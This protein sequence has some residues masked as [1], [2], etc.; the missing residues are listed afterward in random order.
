MELSGLQIFKYLPGAKKLPE[1][2][3]KKC[4][5]PTCM[6]FALK[7]AKQQTQIEKCPHAPEELCSF[8]LEASKIQQHELTMSDEIKFGGETVMFRHEKT[9]VNKTVIAVTLYSNDEEFDY[10][11]SKIKDYEIER[12]G[13]IFRVQ[14]IYLVDCGNLEACV[15]KI[16]DYGFALILETPNFEP[17]E[18]IS[19]LNPIIVSENND[20]RTFEGNVCAIGNTVEELEKSSKNLLDNGKKQ[21]VLYPD[22]TKL[23]NSE[24]IDFLTQ[25]RR[26]A[27][28]SKYEPFTYPV[29][30]RIREQNP[31]KA[32]SEASLFI[33]RY[34]N[35]LVFDL[36]NEALLTAIFTLRQNIYT[37]PQKPLQVESKVYELNNPDE[38]ALVVMTTNFALTYFAV[39]NE[40]EA[41]GYPIYLVIMP[42]DGM[43]VLTAW[44]ADK[45]TPEMAAK[46]I[47]S[48]PVLNTVKHKQLVIPGLLSHIR[49]DIQ[50]EL[51]DWEIIVGTNEAYKI[52]EFVKTRFKR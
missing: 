31:L 41:T 46:M 8:F 17:D 18:L 16:K 22:L 40:F 44:S 37:N 6:A 49:D 35:I 33:C 34:A 1:T 32:A 20:Y 11:L 3:C 12:V 27:I 38:N 2:N 45:F 25:L 7:L 48:N 43:S 13:E 14:A 19:S 36:F 4:G 39:A 26:A 24:K 10:K 23:N 52:Q 42:S 15:K 47:S 29:M 28:I 50:E 21:I 5:F 51:P 9:F 30:M